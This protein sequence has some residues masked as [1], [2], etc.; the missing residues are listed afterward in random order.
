MPP[1]MQAIPARRC[2]D[3]RHAKPIK[4]AIVPRWVC[5]RHNT[6]ASYACIDWRPSTTTPANAHG[7]IHEPTDFTK[8]G[9]VFSDEGRPLGEKRSAWGGFYYLEGEMTEEDK[10]VQREHD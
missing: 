9:N 4:R 5:Q 3:C 8:K 6:A 7:R 2:C 1:S 10:E